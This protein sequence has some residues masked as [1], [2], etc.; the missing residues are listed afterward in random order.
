MERTPYVRAVASV[1]SVQPDLL[2][3]HRCHWNAK[4]CTPP[5]HVPV[6]AL[7][8]SPTLAVP[9]IV[10]VAVFVGSFF[11]ET[12]PVELEFVDD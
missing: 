7:I 1:T 12:A 3:S 11:D 2:L 9:E 4:V 6:V 5:L 10:G 8:S